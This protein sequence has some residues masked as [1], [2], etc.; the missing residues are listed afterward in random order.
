LAEVMRRPLAEVEE[1][2]RGGGRL[3]TPT[4]RAQSARIKFVEVHPL[5]IMLTCISHEDK[6]RM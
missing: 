5:Q 3:S 4:G 6:P 2:E 1:E